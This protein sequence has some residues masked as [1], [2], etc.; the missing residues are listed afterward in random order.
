MVV[1]Y[2]VGTRTNNAGPS[3]AWY[4]QKVLLSKDKRN[5]EP[6]EAFIK[7]MREWI[8]TQKTETTEIILFLAANEKWKKNSKIKRLAETINLHNLNLEGNYNFPDSHP[9]ITNPSRSTTIDYCLCTKNVVT[10]V[11]YATMA[12]YNLGVLGDH[13]GFF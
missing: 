4:Q 10:S 9:S 13:R 3:T 6:S 11:V 5:I 2:R 1:G 12:P 7:D 8:E